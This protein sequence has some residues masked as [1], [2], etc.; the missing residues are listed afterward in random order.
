MN[1]R[2]NITKL[3]LA[4]TLSLSALGCGLSAQ[5]QRVDWTK[6]PAYVDVNSRITELDT[7]IVRYTAEGRLSRE[8]LADIK[9]RLER[10][11]EEFKNASVNGAKPS[12]WQRAR[13]V[14]ELDK[15]NQD[16]Q[17]RT[18]S[19]IA[20]STDIPGRRVKIENDITEAM[21]SGRITNSEAAAFRSRLEN[22][23]EKER[24][25]RADGAFSQQDQ[26]AL[27]YELDQIRTMLEKSLRTRQITDAK[28]DK[29]QA[30]IDARVTSMLA[31]GRITNEV[32]L[33]IRA[34]ANRVSFKER[35]Y[36]ENDGEL[37]TEEI[38]DLAFSL[39][40]IDKKLD[41]YSPI[42]QSPEE[43]MI[44]DREAEIKRLIAQNRLANKLSIQQAQGFTREYNA[45]ESL[46]AVYKSNGV[47][48]ADE[49]NSLNQDL[50][51]LRDRITKSLTVAT[52]PAAFSARKTALKAKIMDSIT[53]RR[54]RP[55]VHSE[56]LLDELARIDA[57][58]QFYLSDGN[59]D[60][61][62]VLIISRDLDSLTRTLEG[63]LQALQSLGDRRA[64][65]ELKLNAALAAKRLSL[66]EADEF[67]RQIARISGME[68]AYRADDMLTDEEM[69]SVSDEYERLE[70]K[71]ARTLPPLPN[72]DKM[73]AEVTKK[74][75]EAR[76][77]GKISETDAAPMKVELERIESVERV[78]RNSDNTLSD[79]EVVSLKGDIEKL[80]SD[81]DIA[82]K[83]SEQPTVVVN[84]T[85]LPSDSRNH[86]AQQYIGM[87]I[88]KGTIGG[89]P[90]GTFKPDDGI[91]RAQFAAII[92]KALGLPTAG[93][94]AE[95]KDLS[96]KHWAYKAISSAVE[97]GLVGGFPDGSFRPEDKITRTQ[98]LVIL[99]KALPGGNGAPRLL[100]R[101]KDGSEVPAW[102]I[103]SVAKV[104]QA[105]ILVNYPDA[106][107][108]RA[109]DNATRAE[110]AAL[111]YQT[112]ANLGQKLPSIST[113]LDAAIK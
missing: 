93:R 81:I 82:I 16:I 11:R 57:K 2:G 92:V 99:A 24:T 94:N 6:V 15:L 72:I 58:E 102:A 39:E 53:S 91:S 27:S 87:L 62:E 56:D 110:V 30:D 9:D 35:R 19:R 47:L 51:D 106:F 90:D 23:K 67:K 112:M 70:N 18:T 4:V 21:Y 7:Q 46:E 43:K 111:T 29:M 40:Q 41:V 98:A 84:V 89:F 105:G 65:L 80:S 83:A 97:G 5:A 75:D 69:L 68:A 103:P 64:Q 1:R 31:A 60:E 109:N 100:D 48:S 22:T 45:I 38:V 32:A 20:A 3:I 96:D 14:L 12:V 104:A 73:Q 113:G 61:T 77:A 101:Y 36:R 107:T 86:W 79:W 78:F 17:L 25:L 52:P 54:L 95:F 55:G 71:L 76:G 42:A 108:I 37:T 33:Q 85:N 34:E 66:G 49:V 88:D 28:I 63:A 59:M 10:I 74:L 13:L 44:D 8:H 26:L 50:D